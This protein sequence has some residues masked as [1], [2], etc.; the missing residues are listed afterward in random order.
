VPVEQALPI[1]RGASPRHDGGPQEGRAAVADP[2]HV[3]RLRQAVE[4]W[5]TW[6]GRAGTLLTASLRRAEGMTMPK[7]ALAPPLAYGAWWLWWRLPKWQL[8]SLEPKIPTENPK[9]RADVEDN[10]R[11]TAGQLIGG[12]A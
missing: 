1:D 2:K 10:F 7:I 5:N 8:K 9:E 6:R 3:N 4:M 11:K 12:A